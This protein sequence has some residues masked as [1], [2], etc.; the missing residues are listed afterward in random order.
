[1]SVAAFLSRG[2]GNEYG[3]SKCGCFT[4][5][6]AIKRHMVPRFAVGDLQSVY[7][8][9]HNFDRRRSQAE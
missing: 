4:E 8:T 5:A 7:L 6:V 3:R 2:R 1:M 9:S